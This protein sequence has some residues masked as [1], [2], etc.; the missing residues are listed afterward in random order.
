MAH[1]NHLVFLG[2]PYATAKRFA[3]PQPLAPWS[4]VKDATAI[5]FAAPQTFS[6]IPG[7]AAS[8]PQNEDCLNLNVFT[9]AA[10]NS[11]RPVMV[12]IHGG[13][14]THG[15]GYEPLYPS[16]AMSSSSASTI[17]SACSASFICPRSARPETWAC[18][19]SRWRCAGCATTSQASAAI[20]N[21]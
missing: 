7:F 20:P 16:A 19:T 12:W 5:G 3:L 9:P 6:M 4:G 21:G 14:F 18:R 15:A 17:G 8:G 13:G 2:I 11:K 10:D 1:R